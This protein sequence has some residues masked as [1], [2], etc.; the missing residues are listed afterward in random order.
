[1]TFCCLHRR[2][3]RSY[4]ASAF[5]VAV[6]FTILCSVP[7]YAAGSDGAPADANGVLPP[8]LAPLSN[9]YVETN[10]QVTMPLTVGDDGPLSALTLTATS[11]NQHLV[12]NAALSFTGIGALT[13]SPLHNA[14]GYT[15]ITVTVSDGD[16]TAQ[17]DFLFSVKQPLSYFLVEGSTGA[18]F[19]RTSRLQ[20]RTP[21]RS[22][23]TSS[24]TR[25][26][27]PLS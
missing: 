6:A 8:T 10:T 26:M 12:P 25:T 9:Q 5:A 27:A 24:S 11:S 14:S 13:I 7:R 1:M 2:A 22:R 19:S 4:A 18:F 23:S 17:H 20:I 3:Q 21:P 15:Q 16:Q